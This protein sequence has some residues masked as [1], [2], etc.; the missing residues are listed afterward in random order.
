[1]AYERSPV[2]LYN[3]DYKKDFST[4]IPRGLLK[5]YFNVLI[6]L[7]RTMDA[8]ILF[9]SGWAAYG[10]K[11][12]TLMLSSTYLAAIIC[13]MV[14]SLFIFPF[15]QLYGAIR[16]NGFIAYFWRII[17]AVGMMWL[18]LAGLG[19]ITK[20]GELYSRLWLAEWM[21]LSLFALIASRFVLLLTLRLMRSHGLNERRVVIIGAGEMGVKLAETIQQALWT[22]FRITTFLDD[23]A[24]N[25]PSAIRDIPVAQMPANL[26]HYLQSSHVDE[27][28]ITL[29]L[30]AEKRVKEILYQ[31]RHSTMTTRYLLDIF[32]LDLLNHSITDLAGFPVLNIQSTPM[33]GVN[34]VVKA[35]EDR[36]IAA[37]ILILISPLMFL[38]AL[39]VKLTSAGPVFFKQQRLGWDG[40]I[41]KV[42]KF[43]TMFTHQESGGK[44]TQ[45]TAHDKRVTP[46]GRFLRRT[47]LDELPQF[48]NVLQGRMSIVG[49]RPHA[50]A[51][52]EQYKDS[53]HVYMQRHR[54]KPGIT[55]WAQ[56][57]GWRGETDTLDK[58]QKRV[59]FDLFY[60]NNWS[61]WFDLKIILLTFI[62]G[63]VNRNAY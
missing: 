58:M 12:G 5:E 25:K 50:L 38:I 43:R 54:M 23:D 2:S 15:F 32:G 10:A 7:V 48:I 29:P 39:C 11:F 34:R 4:M 3:H 62:K 16:S 13:A 14:L 30:R 56:V 42:Y 59:E 46:L 36:I 24:T 20:T 51:H 33:R 6:Q 27:I 40:K 19:F 8:V 60:I 37:L 35:I 61:L 17:Q 18:L 53:I 28:W 22:G 55:G 26:A 21:A 44:V 45:A 31:L 1:M 9:L 63:F 52:N 57:N 47:S 41:I 49:P